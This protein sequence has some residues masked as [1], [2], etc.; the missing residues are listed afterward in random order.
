MN[1]CFNSNY[2]SLSTNTTQSLVFNS[3][4]VT[5]ENQTPLN[6]INDLADNTD[7][8]MDARD[9]ITSTSSNLEFLKQHSLFNTTPLNYYPTPSLTVNP[10]YSDPKK[11][12]L[13]GSGCSGSSGGRF[14]T[15]LPTLSAHST[16][17]ATAIYDNKTMSGLI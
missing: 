7:D 11:L 2:P 13:S 16:A 12:L 15:F 10:I 8:E 4:H 9:F 14:S 5:N 3:N 17:T 1:F 6:L